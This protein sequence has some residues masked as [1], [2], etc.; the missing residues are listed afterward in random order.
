M[1]TSDQRH[2]IGGLRRHLLYEQ[3]GFRENPFGVTPNPKF[4]YESRTHSEAKA[5]LVIG[6]ECGVGFQALIASPGMGKTTLLFHVLQRFEQVAHTALLFQVHGS[7][8]DFLRYL[9]SE[10]GETH[11]PS[12]VAGIQNA[13]NEFLIRQQHS[14]RT[15][16]IV[17]DEAQNLDIEVLEALRL[18][19]N[20]ETASEKMLQIILAGQPQLAQTLAKPELGQLRQRISMFTTLAP[21]GR[22]DTANYI[23]HR[24]RRAG[25]AGE[26]LF[27]PSAVQAV[28]RHSSGI[29]RNI[30]TLCFNALLLTH[31]TERKQ[32][33]GDAIAEV[34]R[35]RDL[36]LLALPASAEHPVAA[37]TLDGSTGSTAR[38]VE[39]PLRV[40]AGGDRSC[41]DMAQ[42]G[43]EG[44]Q[45]L[46]DRD[47]KGGSLDDVCEEPSQGPASADVTEVTAGASQDDVIRDSGSASLPG[48]TL[49]TTL[50][51]AAAD[52]MTSCAST[53]DTNGIERTTKQ[54]A[55]LIAGSLLLLLGLAAVVSHGR[56]LKASP[57]G[58]I[59]NSARIVKQP[60][61]GH[62][63]PTAILTNANTP[64]AMQP[65]YEDNAEPQGAGSGRASPDRDRPV[66]VDGL[67]HYSTGSST[68][69]VLSLDGE[70]KYVSR[71][72]TSPDRI[73]F[74][75]Q[76]TRLADSLTGQ[77]SEVSESAVSRI[78]VAQHEA[79]VSRVALVTKGLCDYTERFASNPSRF[80]IEVS[81]RH[82]LIDNSLQ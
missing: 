61:K 33:D 38:I 44:S 50:M 60:A 8:A 23:E 2:A 43:P 4:L 25:Y 47:I 26:A 24:L 55:G 74:D 77:R 53:N 32:I 39:L 1:K 12:D 27:T 76:D 51:A 29:P 58:N 49:S 45:A 19:S 63:G 28:W 22:E 15:V 13:I 72:L 80:I 46:T 75:L 59:G 81:P 69:I 66:Y 57:V 16:I 6:L 3:F 78:R 35:D 5:S 7:S 18:L 34:V 79:R 36:G 9:L 48:E 10:L 54:R 11:V 56:G 52:T 62:S 73:F 20:F 65:L 31:S 17:V 64:L 82:R 71:R 42:E 30:N 21:F 37:D 68:T 40:E 14:G 70:V 67:E 41:R